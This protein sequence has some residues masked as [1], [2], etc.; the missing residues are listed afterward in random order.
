MANLSYLTRVIKAYLKRPMDNRCPYCHYTQSDILGQKYLLV[1]LRK[2]KN[3]GLMFRFPKEDPSDSISYYQ[4]QYQEGL[5]TDCPDEKA[6]EK[7]FLNNFRGSAKDLSRKIDLVNQ[8][9]SSGNVLDF[10]C[11]WGYGVW[12]FQKAGYN[13]AGFE[14]SVPRSSYGREK[15]GVNII[16]SLHDLNSLPDNS[17]DIVFSSHVL[18]HLPDINNTFKLF[19]RLLKSNGILALFM[20]DCNDCDIPE[21]FHKKKVYAFGEKHTIAYNNLFLEKALL[22][23]GFRNS[24]IETVSELGFPELMVFASK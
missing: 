21:V 20:P 3:C 8:V 4:E 9:V 6:L 11:S 15:L 14:I 24:R 19:Y 13:A 10:G 16:D 2:C 1:Q 18:E 12:Q 7:L 17:F 22:N 23:H 5:T